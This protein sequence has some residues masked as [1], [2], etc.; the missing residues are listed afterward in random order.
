MEDVDWSLQIEQRKDPSSTDLSLSEEEAER[1][2]RLAALGCWRPPLS[3]AHQRAVHYLEQSMG[4]M[5]SAVAYLH[6]QGIKHKDL[7]PSNIL[8]SP[9]GP[10]LT[11]FGTATDFS[12]LTQSVTDDGERGTPK[13]FAPEVASF[14]PSGRAADIFSL[15][16]IFFEMITLILGYT[17]EEM[18]VVRPA[19]DKS[20]QSN[21]DTITSW[22][23]TARIASSFTADQ[24]FM[25]LVRRMLAPDP[26]VRPTAKVVEEEIALI[27]GFIFLEMRRRHYCRHCCSLS[28][29]SSSDDLK[30]PT[31]KIP[32]ELT[33]GNTYEFQDKSDGKKHAYTF[34]IRPSLPD[35]IQ[36][37]HIFKVGSDPEF[38]LQMA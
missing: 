9:D 15:G 19:N 16:C 18:K 21:L 24:Y 5:A 4:C 27:D 11:D 7:K 34:F 10:W 31:K 17:L 1:V 29:F 20:F 23:R 37:V 35:L 36:E 30:E 6:E 14:N 28:R 2:C 13:Y 33:I 32:M 12:V 8:L 26:A 38:S 3:G 22:F 25:G